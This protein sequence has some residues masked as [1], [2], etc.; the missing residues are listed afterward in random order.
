MQM[1]GRVAM[2]G[3]SCAVPSLV[4]SHL[5][6]PSLTVAC[7]QELLTVIQRNASELKQSLFQVLPAATSGARGFPPA[8][9]AAQDHDC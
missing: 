3:A 2:V 6:W 1:V 7:V 4:E 9:L 5:L 8:S